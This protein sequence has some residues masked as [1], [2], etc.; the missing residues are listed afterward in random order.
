MAS[1]TSVG[2][3][4]L[5]DSFAVLSGAKAQVWV[6][7][8]LSPYLKLPVLLLVILRDVLKVAIIGVNGHCAVLLRTGDF[9]KD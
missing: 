9:L 7:D 3:V 4:G 2:D 5:D 1:R 8:C 6:I